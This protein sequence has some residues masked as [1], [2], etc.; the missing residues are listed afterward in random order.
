MDEH[1]IIVPASELKL[2]NAPALND[3]RNPQFI[4]EA[5]EI[6]NPWH[7]RCRRSRIL[8]ISDLRLPTG[9]DLR[10]HGGAAPRCL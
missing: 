10:R 1:G 3:E 7:R 5:K 4:V 2:P 9:E 8:A 6:V